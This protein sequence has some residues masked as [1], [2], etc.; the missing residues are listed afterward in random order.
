MSKYLTLF[1]FCLVLLSCGS[2]KKAANN[3]HGS[4]FTWDNANVYFLL[5]DRFYNADK[6]NDF[7]HPVPPAPYRGYMGGDIKGITAKIN[8][9]YF[10]KLGINAIWMTPLLQNIDGYVD[11]GTGLSYGFHGYWIKDWTKID[12]RLG[13]ED[14]VREM[15]KAAH[16]KGIRIL[17]DAVI[18]HTGPVTPT[19]PQWSDDWV[20][21]EP[22]CT[23]KDYKTTIECTLVKNLP[24]IKT[25]SKKEVGIP[26]ALSEKWKKEG[27]YD[28]EVKELDD[29]FKRTGYPR[30]PYFYIIKWLTDLIRDFGIDGFRVDT[31]KHT[32]ENV[33]KDLEIESS[34]AFEDWKKQN[35]K[36]KLDDEPFFMVGEVYNYYVGSGRWFD[37][38]DRKVDY[39]DNG[40]HS[41]INFDFKYDANKTYSELFNKYANALGTDLQGKSV[42]NYISSHDDGGPFDKERK[43]TYESATKLLLTPGQ[44]QIYYGDESARSLTVAANGDATLRSFMNWD[45]IHLESNKALGR[46]WQKLGQFRKNHPSVGAGQ[47][48]DL[49]NNVFG[50]TYQKEQYTDKVVIAVD[51]K[52][53]PKIIPT[54][55]LFEDGQYVVDYYSET[56]AQVLKGKVVINSPYEIVLLENNSNK[57]LSKK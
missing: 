2:G 10:E 46:H 34:K 56:S 47:N 19:D 25:E 29:F 54:G 23:Y 53:G 50:R 33:W 42:M 32:E 38:G 31:A 11:E 1:S 36:D 21:T 3:F 28:Q 41:L 17:M 35:P 16:K 9:G 39:F 5:T 7:Q 57:L 13:T 44:A 27:R 37:F 52:K 6:S 18:N 40:F 55:S 15:V 14:D 49:G 43:R 12:P 4:H 51:Q 30:L 45:E 22:N 20:R 24:D 48:T 26:I 8:E